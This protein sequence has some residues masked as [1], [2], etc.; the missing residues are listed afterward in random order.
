MAKLEKDLSGL[1]L[2]EDFKEQNL[3]WLPSPDNYNN[4][5]FTQSGLE[6]TH[7]DMYKTITIQKPDEDN[8]IFSCKINH[9]PI[10]KFDIGG[11]IIISDKKTYIECQSYLANEESYITNAD[12]YEEVLKGEIEKYI[13]HFVTYSIISDTGV[14]PDDGVIDDPDPTHPEE[15][16]YDETYPYIR[17][18]CHG[19][20]Y[21]FFASTDNINWVELGSGVLDA[22]RIGFFLYSHDENEELTPFYVEHAAIYK[23]N[24]IIIN[25]VPSDCIVEATTTRDGYID[26]LF[27]ERNVFVKRKN[28]QVY[29]DTSLIE[30]PIDDVTLNLKKNNE[31]ILYQTFNQ[32]VGGDIFTMWYDIDMY[33]DQ[34]KINPNELYDLGMFINEVTY[35]RVDLF[36]NEEFN[37]TNI[38]VELKKY[39]DYY[40]GDENIGIAVYE[41]GKTDYVFKDKII[42]DRI[43]SFESQ[44]FVIG[45]TNR[46]SYDFY[47]MVND[48]RFKIL[49]SNL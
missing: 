35:V 40:V 37:V 25:N 44:S 47:N 48:K 18:I 33:I 28:N 42:I 20:T 30:C 16:F 38:Q 22:N 41:Q 2:Y 45:L 15:P 23:S 46:L 8:F 9:T 29:I 12:R 1:L 39:S 24:Y 11:V 17:V 13:D 31:V 3:I 14:I 32:I 34:Q 49:L 5:N 43:D 27:S 26:T 21:S 19:V 7:S 6:I 10:D 36:N 4:I